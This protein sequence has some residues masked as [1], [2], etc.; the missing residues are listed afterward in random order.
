VLEDPRDQ[1]HFSPD[2]SKI[3]DLTP[4]GLVIVSAADGS[5]LKTFPMNF[6]AVSSVKWLPDS[7]GLSFVAQK[8]TTSNIYVQS[9]SGGAPL[10]KTNFTT[11]FVVAYAWSPDGKRLI[12][13]RTHTPRDAVILAD[14]TKPD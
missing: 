13:T 5:I 3:A 6:E 7:S 11:D 8:G 4:K 9:L 10:Q 14:T 12:M 2:G 1:A